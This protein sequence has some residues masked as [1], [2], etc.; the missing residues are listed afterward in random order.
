M[1]HTCG[2]VGELSLVLEPYT[3][4]WLWDL[5]LEQFTTCLWITDGRCCCYSFL[6]LNVRHL[7]N[8]NRVL[9]ITLIKGHIYFAALGVTLQIEYIRNTLNHI[10][11]CIKLRVTIITSISWLWVALWHHIG[12]LLQDCDISSA[13]GMEMPQTYTMPSMLTYC[14]IFRSQEMGRPSVPQNKLHGALEDTY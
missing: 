2:F 14:N 11:D 3:M 1:H 9:N 6:W 4:K 13:S 12:D 7:E 5:P 10:F 8:Y